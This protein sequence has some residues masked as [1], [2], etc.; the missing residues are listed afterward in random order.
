MAR[1]ERFEE[2][3]AWQKARELTRE[4]Y[5]TTGKGG[6]RPRL[7]AGGPDATGRPFRSCRTSRRGRSGSFRHE[8]EAVEVGGAAPCAEL[9]S[10]FYV[11][12]DA[13]RS[14]AL[15]E[16]FGWRWQDCKVDVP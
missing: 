9:R 2:L 10:Q 3:I 5:A 11:A 6:V 16:G 7:W 15:W 8:E 12:F 13:G 14:A 1:I 4:V